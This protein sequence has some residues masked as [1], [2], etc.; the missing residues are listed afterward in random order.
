MA[1]LTPEDPTV[2]APRSA[3]GWPLSWPRRTRPG[4]ANGGHLSARP[5]SVHRQSPGDRDSSRHRSPGPR[6]IL[7]RGRGPEHRGALAVPRHARLGS[8]R[9]RCRGAG[10]W[11]A[12]LVMRGLRK[13]LPE[14]GRLGVDSLPLD[15]LALTKPRL[16]RRG[17][18]PTFVY[19]ASR[20]RR[21]G[22][23]SRSDSRPARC[24][25]PPGLG[26]SNPRTGE[27]EILDQR[28][29]ACAGRRGPLRPTRSS[30]APTAASRRSQ[31]GPGARRTPRRRGSPC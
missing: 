25:R 26:V 6:T 23:E 5:A 13:E 11:R 3:A 19:A 18:K 14:L 21:P 31:V 24:P 9:A 2:A 27:R 8:E 20:A 4:S 16:G 1:P 22:R 7:P 17:S 29:P 10:R 28:V 12:D 30:S 15:E